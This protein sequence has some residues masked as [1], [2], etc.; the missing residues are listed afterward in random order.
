MAL[1][2]YDLSTVKDVFDNAL[3][4]GVSQTTR[5]SVRVVVFVDKFGFVIVIVYGDV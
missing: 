5:L 4:V 1:P 2:L 3:A